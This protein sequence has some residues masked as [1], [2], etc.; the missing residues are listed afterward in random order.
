MSTFRSATFRLTA[1]YLLILTVISLLFSGIVYSLADREF[2]H[3]AGPPQ[4]QLRMMSLAPNE[5]EELNN[6]RQTLAD[7]SR[8][9]LLGG[10]VLFNMAVVSLGGVASYLMAR[11]T[12]K[13]I[14]EMVEAQARF[15]SD[16]AHELKTPLTVMQSELEIAL[17]NPKATKSTYEKMLNSSLDEVHRLKELTD[18]LLVLASKQD[19]EISSTDIEAVAIEAVNHIIPTAASKKISVDNS[20]GTITALA[21]SDALIDTLVILL[22]NAIKYSPSKSHISLSAKQTSKRVIL[23]V[24]DNGPG[25]DV[26][27][28]EYIFDRFYRADTSR[29]RGES[30][31]HGIGLSIAKRLMELQNGSIRLAH[32]STKGSRFE[33]SI[34]QA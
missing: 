34:P 31:G 17:R 13:P 4:R 33:V 10:L 19:L 6:T 32:T 30:E 1:W 23:S 27:D 25:I 28:Q 9:R 12:L 20:V 5:I 2:E 7:E 3:V 26:R 16:A 15:S 22:D 14:E 11:R 8:D 29:T 24:Q 21:N 18:R